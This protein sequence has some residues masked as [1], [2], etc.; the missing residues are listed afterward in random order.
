M[1]HPDGSV[2]VGVDRSGAEGTA[3]RLAAVEA[4]LRG[5]PLDLLSAYRSHP[6]EVRRAAECTPQETARRR[7]VD[8]AAALRSAHPHLRVR[9]ELVAGE[10]GGA[11]IA[12]SRGAGLVVAGAAGLPG[13]CQRVAAHAAAPVVVARSGCRPGGPVLLGVDGSFASP[14][15]TGFAFDEAAMRGAVLVPVYAWPGVADVALSGVDPFDYDAREARAEAHRVL[16]EGLA[17]WSEKYPDVRVER[18]AVLAAN[19]AEELVH[20]TADASMLVLAAR[21]H[22]G[23]GELLL[24]AVTRFALQHAHC[25]VAVLRHALP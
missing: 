22:F 21:S 13:L 8:T 10:L 3:V 2:V 6:D 4:A 16:A 24:G 19:A 11:L 9:T 7:L 17:G 23:A 20:Q 5:R 18:R 12:R 14:E 15:A 25:P 1:Q